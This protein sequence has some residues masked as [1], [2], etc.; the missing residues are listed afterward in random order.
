MAVYFL[1]KGEV[2]FSVPECEDLVFL[3]I[4]EGDA[5]G[6]IDLVPE[7]KQSVIEKEVARTFS[8]MALENS[9]VLCLSIEVLQSA[10]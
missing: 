6:I 1:T 10:F 3:L 2:A 8:V 5:F 7:D 4:E 9:E